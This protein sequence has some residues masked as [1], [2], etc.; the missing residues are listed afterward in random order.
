MLWDFVGFI[1]PINRRIYDWTA[2]L[3]L[4]IS[5]GK[6]QDYPRVYTRTGK[7]S[8]PIFAQLN[9]PILASNGAEGDIHTTVTLG[10]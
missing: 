10:N 6:I 1:N 3:C 5:L 7:T 8:F 2:V 4:N 9:L